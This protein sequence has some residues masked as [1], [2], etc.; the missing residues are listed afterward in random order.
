MH[1]TSL[2]RGP[3]CPASAAAQPAGPQSAHPGP[4]PQ[5]LLQAP[6]TGQ[7]HGVPSPPTQAS[8][9]KANAASTPLCCCSLEGKWEVE[10]RVVKLRALRN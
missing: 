6:L 10:G 2:C 9:K 8:N 5:A 1:Q 3:G 4:G 7:P